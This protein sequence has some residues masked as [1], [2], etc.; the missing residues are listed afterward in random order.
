VSLQLITLSEE[1]A[2]ETIHEVAE[3]QARCPK[4]SPQQ[5]ATVVSDALV[6]S[7]AP[8]AAQAAPRQSKRPGGRAFPDYVKKLVAA[9][10][11]PFKVT[12]ELP[13]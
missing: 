1:V 6:I 2:R 13:A 7:D 4:L 3:R 10:F 8:V 9:K 12:C 11:R 5:H